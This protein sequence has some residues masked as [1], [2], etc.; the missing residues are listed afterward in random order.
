MKYA[1]EHL[2]YLS[3]YK[4]KTS[5]NKKYYEKHIRFLKKILPGTDYKA[6]TELFNKKFSFNI[7]AEKLKA[8]CQRAGLK[9]GLSGR[10]PKGHVP[11]NKGVKGV[12]NPGSEKTWF[13]KGHK[14]INE[15]PVGSERTNADGYVEV[16]VSDTVVPRQRRWKAKHVILWEKKHGKVPKGHCLVFLDGDRQNITL[17]NL[18]MISFP[19]RAVMCHLKYFTGDKEKTKTNITLARMKVALADRK[20]ELLARPPGSGGKILKGEENGN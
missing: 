6:V 11:Q 3:G 19:V 16:K 12:W 17:D 8:L 15:K 2:N 18:M 7:T 10:F 20:R 13:K 1:P 5:W 4:N 9:N 14:N